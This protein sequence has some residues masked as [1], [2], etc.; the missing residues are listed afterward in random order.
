LVCFW[1]ISCA[2]TG[3]SAM[4][5]LLRIS[6]IWNA[7]TNAGVKYGA[8]LAAVVP[9]QRAI[10]GFEWYGCKRAGMPRF[11]D[12]NRNKVNSTPADPEVRLGSGWAG[13]A[14]CAGR[15]EIRGLKLAPPK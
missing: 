12:I 3:P 5:G 4:A 6:I 9:R 14:V 13:A 11:V 1:D 8:V 10:G 7:A 2:A 15:Q